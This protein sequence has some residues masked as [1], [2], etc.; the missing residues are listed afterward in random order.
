MKLIYKFFMAFC[1][2][3]FIAVSIMLALI[4][5]NLSSGFHD[6]VND[7]EISY[8]TEVNQ[9]LAGYYQQHGSWDAF[10]EDEHNWRNLIGAGK[11]R[12]QSPA[13]EPSSLDLPT[14]TTGFSQLLQTQ[15]RLS[16]YDT[17]QDVVVGLKKIEANVFSQKILVDDQLVGWLS[18]IPS[19]L[20]EHSPANDFL[21]QQY[22]SYS[23]ITIAVIAIAFITA[24]LFSRHLVAPITQINTGTTQ[25]IR[26][27]FTGQI[28]SKHHDELSELANSMNVLATTLEKS[29]TERSKWMSDVAHEL[30]TPLTIV[31]GQLTAIQDGIF[32]AD[33]Q[34]LQVMVDQIDS[35]SHL[36][37]DIYQL[38]ITDIGG[39]AY[40]KTPLEPVK[41]LDDMAHGFMVKAK[42]LGLDLD[43]TQLNVACTASEYLVMADRERIIQLFTNL[44]EN[45]CRY[46][47]APGT[48]RLSAET[49]AS[50]TAILIYIEDSSP[51]ISSQDF[52]KVFE[53]FYRVEQSRNREYGGS[54]IGLALCKQIVDAH[55]GTIHADHSNLGG[56]KIEISLPIYRGSM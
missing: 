30:K 47:T 28:E 36:V 37:G 48:I 6:F 44:L 1:I 11:R 52:D 27:D 56:V 55:Q 25:L 13:I 35:M 53:R 40:R 17:N 49:D 51:S 24:W 46:T 4:M 3:S 34:R 8:V 50:E 9:K 29:K 18:F 21:A 42:E 33:E 45:S 38:S 12:S 32:Q 26:G 23:L 5:Q 19:K 10:K 7:A 54:G 43:S 31:R 39:L 15:R 16:L 41:V 2:T 20:A 22:I 14:D